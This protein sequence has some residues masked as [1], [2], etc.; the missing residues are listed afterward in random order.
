MRKLYNYGVRGLV[1]DWIK[2]FL[3]QRTMSVRVGDS[4]SEPITPARGVPQGSVLGPR[5]FLAFINVLPQDLGHNVL[6][7]ADDAKIWRTV[8]HTDDHIA[9]Q[10]TID[11]AYRWSIANDIEF[12]VSKCKVISMRHKTRFFYVLGN[13]ILP[14]ATEERDLGVMVQ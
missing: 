7:V 5:L 12:N 4:L 10:Q 8:T 2:E 3:Q 14:H 9:L 11:A 13:Q 6:L 1:I